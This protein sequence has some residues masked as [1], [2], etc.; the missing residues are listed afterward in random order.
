MAFSAYSIT[1]GDI[2]GGNL[3]TNLVGVEV[4][5]AGS[6]A[7][8]FYVSPTQINFLVPPNLLPGTVTLVVVH[9][10]LAGPQISLSLQDVAPALFPNTQDAGYVIAQQWPAYSLIS[11]ESPVPPG[12]IVILYATGLGLTEPYPALPTEIPTYAG[13]IVN[14]AALQVLLDG[15]PLEASRVLYAGICPGW[16]GLYQIDLI[17]PDDVSPNPEIRVAIGNHESSPGLLLAVE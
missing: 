15:T 9:D 1:S 8:L 7:P 4:I 10:S 12:G 6:P 13:E 17:L 2:A 14:G 3:P 5:V 11:P 16:A